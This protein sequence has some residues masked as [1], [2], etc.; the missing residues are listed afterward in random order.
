MEASLYTEDLALV[1]TVPISVEIRFHMNVIVNICLM[2]YVQNM[3][4]GVLEHQNAD[5]VRPYGNTFFKRSFSCQIDGDYNSLHFIYQ[6]FSE[7]I[8]FSIYIKN[9]FFCFLFFFETFILLTV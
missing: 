1:L 7:Y 8:C 9:L 4:L 2:L 5:Q 3:A 6:V